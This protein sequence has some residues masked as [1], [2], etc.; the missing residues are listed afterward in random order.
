MDNF[1][2]LVVPGLSSSSSR[3]SAST[4]TPKAQSSSS[5]ESETPTD[6]VTTRR[7]KSACGKPKQTNPD[8]EASGNR[9][10]VHTEDET[11]KED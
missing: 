2:P 4:S 5:S 9:G 6:P 3:S 10:L 1:V 11:D 8:V 7:A